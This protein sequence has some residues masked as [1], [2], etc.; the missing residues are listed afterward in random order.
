MASVVIFD[1]GSGSIKAG[2]S[3]DRA[4]KAIIPS[5]SVDSSILP[6]ERGH[7]K[8]WDAVEMV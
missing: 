5:V 8:D 4:P 3:G 1:N 2:F 7:I 6:I